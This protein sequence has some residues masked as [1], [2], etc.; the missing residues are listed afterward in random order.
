MEST[1]IHSIYRWVPKVLQIY[2]PKPAKL[3]LQRTFFLKTY[4]LNFYWSIVDLKVK[5]RV[6]QS[7]PMLCDPKDYTVPGIFQAKILEWVAFPFSRGSSPPRDWT[8][9]SHIA[10]EFF[11]S[12]ATRLIYS[13]LLVSGVWH[14]ESVRHTHLSTKNCFIHRVPC[15]YGQIC[16]AIYP[17]ACV[18]W[19]KKWIICL[20]RRNKEAG[21]DYPHLLFPHS[22]PCEL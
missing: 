7:C 10:G 16:A 4:I 9:V 19:E 2:S 18:L 1:S 3:I 20:V 6:A 5:V 14:S 22:F 21:T 13:V 15:G 17:R 8:Q 11:T 12:W